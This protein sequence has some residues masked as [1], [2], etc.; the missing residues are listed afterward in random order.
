MLS[1]RGVVHAVDRAPAPLDS[2]LDL[3]GD[4]CDVL[5][6]KRVLGNDDP[7]ASVPGEIVPCEEFYSYSAK[8]EKPST[9][10]IPAPVSEDVVLR[11]QELA[12]RAF[13]AIDC[14]GMAR[15]DFFLRTDGEVLVNEINTIPGFTSISM[16]AKLW[17]ASGIAYAGLLDRLIELAMEAGTALQPASGEV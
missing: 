14:R 7:S 1:R 6:V 10:R 9:L 13:R 4:A 3:G 12:I 17:E 2:I 5:L 16:Y 11:I 15:V 8:Y